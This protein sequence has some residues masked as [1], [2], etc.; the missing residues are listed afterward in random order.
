VVEDLSCCF[1]RY[2]ADIIL[3]LLDTKMEKCD[4]KGK[5]YSYI[6]ID[7][8][9]HRGVVPRWVRLVWS[10]HR[11]AIYH[12]K[13]NHSSFQ[14]LCRTLFLAEAF[15]GFSCGEA[16]IRVGDENYVFAGGDERSEAVADSGNVTVEG[17]VRGNSADGGEVKTD[18]GI[19]VRFKEGGD[20]GI[21]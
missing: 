4:R 8:V 1:N 17:R 15:R 5:R 7:P 21:D 18:C 12:Y 10:R 9:R 14:A 3:R 11:N 16:A 13:A 20:R 19:A 2:R 6:F